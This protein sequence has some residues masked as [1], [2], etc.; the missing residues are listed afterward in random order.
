MSAILKE[1]ANP[2]YRRMPLN[3]QERLKQKIA[4]E[5]ADME[6]D[7]PE[8]NREMKKHLLK[9]PPGADESSKNENKVHIKRM[10]AVLKRQ[11]DRAINKAETS[12][13][14]KRA[15]TL[16]AEMRKMMV[17]IEDTQ[18]TPSLPGGAANPAF[19]KARN[20]MAKGEMSPQ[21]RQKA[22]ELK[23]ILRLLGKD[24]PEAGNFENFRPKRGE[25]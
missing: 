8:Y 24:D 16:T 25:V 20:A 15:A 5:K 9:N 18:L 2:R 22:H 3:E 7:S 14:E 1:V 23:N 13:L 6:G 21:F 17:P 10:E 12:A 19:Q 4:V 11:G